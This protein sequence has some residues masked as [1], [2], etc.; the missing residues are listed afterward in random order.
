MPSFA[1]VSA[2][3]TLNVLIDGGPTLCLCVSSPSVQQNQDSFVDVQ[4]LPTEDHAEDKSR[5]LKMMKHDM[6]KPAEPAHRG[7][8]YRHS[9]R[10]SCSLCS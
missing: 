6:M 7:P 3:K 8:T 4:G 10:F 9:V 1:K 5:H 2:E